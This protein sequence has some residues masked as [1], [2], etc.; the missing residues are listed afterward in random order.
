[1]DFGAGTATAAA[2]ATV[3]PIP[4]QYA[5]L[6]QGAADRYGVP[7]NILALVAQAESSFNPGAV[8]DNGSSYGFFQIH[9]P[10][11]PGVTAQ[12]AE[13]PAFNVD[14]GARSL[15][16]AYKRYNGN[17]Q[18]TILFNNC[19][20]C[21]DHFAA[22][23]K[24]GPTQNLADASQRYL[25]LVLKPIGGMSVAGT[26]G[27]E[28]LANTPATG[29]APARPPAGSPYDNFLSGFRNA[30]GGA[31]MAGSA[32]ATSSPEEGMLTAIGT[33]APL[34]AAGA[35]AASETPPQ[36]ADQGTGQ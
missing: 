30:L 10:A 25:G 28:W 8:G 36:P 29:G 26:V 32:R 11:H 5:Q 4:A 23:G 20:V 31:S 3:V 17:A 27:T 18:A 19:P 7:V 1:M 35:A 33:S 24:F 14:W 12:Q 22:T 16:Q 13:D 21:A 15:A 6:F 9:L 2:N 34:T